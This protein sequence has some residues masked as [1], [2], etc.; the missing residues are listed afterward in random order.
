MFD[1]TAASS[2][3][4]SLRPHEQLDSTEEQCDHMQDN[5]M[6]ARTLLSSRMDDVR[7][8]KRMVTD[9]KETIECQRRD[10]LMQ[11]ISNAAADSYYMAGPVKIKMNHSTGQA[12][13]LQ[14][15]GDLIA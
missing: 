12:K 15:Y 7:A 13:P 8:L 11:E 14:S 1:D 10:K 6:K 4:E 3:L 5:L 9:T 2:L